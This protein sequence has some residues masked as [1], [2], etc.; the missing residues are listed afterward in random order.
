MSANRS[1]GSVPLGIVGVKLQEPYNNSSYILSFNISEQGNAWVQCKVWKA[2][3]NAAA[4]F[5]VL[6]MK[7][8]S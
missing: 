4:V 5:Y 6:Y 8:A 2:V 7:K 3:T 1:D